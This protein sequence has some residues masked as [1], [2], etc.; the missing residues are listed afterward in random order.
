LPLHLFIPELRRLAA[1]WLLLPLGAMAQEGGLPDGLY[2]EISTP[3]G[4][5]TCELE[6]ARVPLPVANFVGL[7]EGT[8]GPSPRRPFF[9]GLKFHRVAPGFVVQG[10]D[11]LGT[12]EGGPG[13][14]FPDEFSVGLGHDSAGVLSMANDGPDTNG[15]QFF[16]TLA[17]AD[18]LDFMHSAFGRVV[19]GTDVPAK[20]VQGD[21]MQVRILRI[22]AAAIGFRADQAAFDA[23]EARVPRY[24]A[25]REPGPRAHFDDPDKLL[26]ADPPRA[27]NFNYKLANFE[28]A[29]GLRIYARVFAKFVP[30][31]AG[32]TPD[33]FADLL[34][35]S[36]GLDE[37]GVLAVY[38][39][40]IGKWSLSI[41]K[42][43]VEKFAESAEPPRESSKNDRLRL[44]IDM[45]FTNSRRR[46]AKYTVQ[47]AATLPNFLQIPGQKLKISVDAVLDELLL[48]TSL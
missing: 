3:R 42:S 6:Y 44:S 13:Y 18:R 5:I 7:A 19:R 4:V 29:T 34:S 36:L 21:A 2:A 39:S 24:H 33:A 46:E 48:K 45:F 43:M 10:G 30:G 16:I 40:D 14:T 35:R 17:P 47:S 25:E 31:S 20:I 28:R 32:Q 37:D 27:L 11:P 1:A 15:S 23:L 8:L 12:G 26:P 41:G 38:F 22:G 9:D